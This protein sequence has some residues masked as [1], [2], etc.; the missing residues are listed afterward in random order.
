MLIN[1]Y[2]RDV[3]RFVYFQINILVNLQLVFCICCISW[4]NCCN[5][6]CPGNFKSVP[7]DADPLTGGRRNLSQNDSSSQRSPVQNKRGQHVHW[8]L[9]TF[10]CWYFSSIFFVEQVWNLCC[11]CQCAESV[12][13]ICTLYELGRSLASLKHKKQYE[14]LNLGP[15]CKLPRIHRIFKIDSNTKDDDI[16]QIETVD[17]LKVNHA[18]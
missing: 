9:C 5:P 4:F 13:S 18:F 6:V 15:L 10:I 8:G 1:S 3:V 2:T 14:E 7:A 16:Q 11:F 12:S 17:I